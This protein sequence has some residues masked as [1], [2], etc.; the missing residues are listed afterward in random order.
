MSTSP[1]K[2][3]PTGGELEAFPYNR[4]AANNV[5]RRA[6]RDAAPRG[7]SIRR[8][9]KLHKPTPEQITFRDAVREVIK[10]GFRFVEDPQTHVRNWIEG[11]VD[12]HRVTYTS[13]MIPDGQVGA[14]GKHFFRRWQEIDGIRTSMTRQRASDKGH[15][16]GV[17]INAILQEEKRLQELNR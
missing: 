2:P 4:T 5:L 1:D 7:I 6:E 8:G 16:L 17:A 11:T 15:D 9:I 13:R 10:H 3:L 12:G 14:G